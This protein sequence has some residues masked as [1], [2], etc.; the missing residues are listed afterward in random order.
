MKRYSLHYFVN[1]E[2]FTYVPP[3]YLGPY[4]RCW[5]CSSQLRRLRG[6]VRQIQREC[7]DAHDFRIYDHA[8]DDYYDD[9]CTRYKHIVFRRADVN[10]R[11]EDLTDSN[12]YKDMTYE[13]YLKQSGY[14]QEARRDYEEYLLMWRHID[15]ARA[16]GQEEGADI[17]AMIASAYYAHYKAL[18]YF[19]IYRSYGGADSEEQAEYVM[20]HGI[21]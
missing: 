11:W 12:R 20:E 16:A 3:G 8:Y 6:A 7:P 2:D 1:K 19:Y 4:D 17:L 5:G 15:E 9:E 18:K 21:N 14:E 13:E 10:S